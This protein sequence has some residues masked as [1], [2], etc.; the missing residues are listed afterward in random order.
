MAA[1][2]LRAPLTRTTKVAAVAVV[3]T[4][5]L[6][7]VFV[8]ALMGGDEP[9]S[10]PLQPVRARAT[11][12][13]AAHQFGDRVVAEIEL[14]LDPRRVDPASVTLDPDFDPFSVVER[15][16]R[17]SESEG[18]VLLR[19]RF[20]LTCLRV[21]CLPGRTPRE[22][23]L[24]EAGVDYRLRSGESRRISLEWP[25]LTGA[26][27]LDALELAETPRQPFRADLTPPDASFRVDPGRLAGLLLGVALLLVAVAAAL[28]SPELR[29]LLLIRARRRDPLAGM[30]PLQRAL[31]LVERALASGN[32]DDQRKAIDRLARELRR[33]GDDELSAATRQLA[34]S[35]RAPADADLAPIE[36]AERTIGAAR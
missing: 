36:A 24:P 32:A 13:P 1:R 26:S 25:R 6:A 9:E 2:G 22:F 18:A 3:A 8:L 5:A 27:R 10:S 28:L 33:A 31:M 34:W 15:S 29:R 35:A 7:V 19:H 12:A 16:R 11:A 21:A 17:R 30:T 23:P 20:T 14:M 4:G